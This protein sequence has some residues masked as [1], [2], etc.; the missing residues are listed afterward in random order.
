MASLCQLQ[1]SG[2]AKGTLVQDSVA[3]G[4]LSV[5]NQIFGEVN[6]ESDEFQDYPYDG[7]LGLA[8][9]SIATSHAPTF[10]ENLM[11]QEQVL[12]PFFSVHLARGLETGSEV[13]D[14]LVCF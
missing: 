2:S 7:L 5:K 12:V 10:M 13:P 14:F 8:F 6:L 1:A 11:N 9:S 4:S 3:L